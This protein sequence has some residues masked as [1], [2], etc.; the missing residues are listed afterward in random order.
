MAE[1]KRPDNVL[2]ALALELPEPVY[3]DATARIRA[4]MDHIEAERDDLR[5][6]LAVARRILN[7][8]DEALC[9]AVD[10][11]DPKLSPSERDWVVAQARGAHA[12]IVNTFAAIEGEA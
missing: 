10:I 12:D 11:D 7:R 9:M 3:E 8:A 1:V 6:K 2:N 5:A 4:Y